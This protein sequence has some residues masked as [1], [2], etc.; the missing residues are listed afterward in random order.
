MFKTFEYK[1]YD[2]KD[3]SRTAQMIENPYKVFSASKHSQAVKP[4]TVVEYTDLLG[5][6]HRIRCANKTKMKEAM[7][8]LSI[9]KA[10]TAKVKTILSEYPVKMGRI[11]KRFL[12]ELKSELKPMGFSSEFIMKLAGY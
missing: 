11:E 3:T 4:M 8:F 5:N 1:G 6:K 10:E 2:K 7:A 12:S 9:L